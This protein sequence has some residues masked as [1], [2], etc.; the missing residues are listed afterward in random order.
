MLYIDTGVAIYAGFILIFN[1]W[2]WRW[3]KG[4]IE[5]FGN[6]GTFYKNPN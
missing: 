3:D 6:K 5:T 2:L 4:I 1:P